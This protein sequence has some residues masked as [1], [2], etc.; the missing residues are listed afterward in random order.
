MPKTVFGDRYSKTLPIIIQFVCDQFIH[1]L[2]VCI[3]WKNSI[4]ILCTSETI[5]CSTFFCKFIGCF[6]ETILECLSKIMYK[7]PCLW[8]IILNFVAS[9]V[10]CQTNITDA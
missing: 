3:N 5:T 10:V 6:K 9:K 7:F 4:S 8:R 2:L 1:I